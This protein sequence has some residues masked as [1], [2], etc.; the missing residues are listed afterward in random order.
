[1]TNNVT[2]SVLM[3]DA[4]EAEK[5]R[6]SADIKALGFVK[7]GRG[8]D[9]PSGYQAQ[10]YVNTDTREIVL[11]VAGTNDW[12]DISGD[13]AANLNFAT[14]S[15]YHQQFRDGLEYANQINLLATEQRSDYEGYK[16]TTVGHSLGGGI[17]QIYSHTFGWEGYSW[18]A[19]QA[20]HVIQSEGYQAQLTALGLTA[21]GVS[22]KFVNY[23]ENGSIVSELPVGD[24][25][26]L[27]NEQEV[28]HSSNLSVLLGPFIHTYLQ[29]RATQALSY[30][31]TE[32]DT[33][34]IDGYH[35]VGGTYDGWYLEEPN[36]DVGVFDWTGRASDEKAAELNAIRQQRTEHNQHLE[37]FRSQHADDVFGH[38]PS[39]EAYN[40]WLIQD[41]GQEYIWLHGND[42][43][44]IR[45]DKADQQVIETVFDANGNR[46]IETTYDIES[47]EVTHT[48]QRPS[49]SL[50]QGASLLG[51]AAS[52]GITVEELLQF[53]PLLEGVD[54][55][56]AGQSVYLPDSLLSGKLSDLLSVDSDTLAAL[57]GIGL[58]SLSIFGDVLIDNLQ[59]YIRIAE[60][61]DSPLILDLDGDGVETHAKSSNLHFDLDANSFMEQTGWVGA[62]DGL[63][64]VDRNNNGLIDDGTELFGNHT[65]LENGEKAANGFEAL[66]EFDT[67]HDGQVN[68]DDAAFDALRIWRDVNQNGQT[69]SGELSSL[70]DAGVAS[71]R[72]SYD[73][74]NFIDDNNNAHRQVGSFTLNDG[75]TRDL[76]DVWF[77]VDLART[78][79]KDLIDVN[80][81]IAQLPDIQGMGHVRSLHQAMARD[82]S[83]ELQRLVEKFTQ[84]ES[85]ADRHALMPEL[86]YRW[87]GVW[88]VDPTSRGDYVNDA[89]KVEAI[90]AFFGKPFYQW[91]GT[92]ENP[93][94]NA[95]QDIHVA[96][97]QLQSHIY[98]KLAFQTHYKHLLD[99]VTWQYESEGAVSFNTEHLL[100]ALPLGSKEGTDLLYVLDV[101]NSLRGLNDIGEQI[102]LQASKLD[103][104]A[105]KEFWGYERSVVTWQ[106][107]DAFLSTSQPLHQ[108]DHY[109]NEELYGGRSAY[110]NDIL[111]GDTRD[112]QLSGGQGNDFLFGGDGDDQLE[113]GLGNDI[114]IGGGGNDSLFG[115]L[116]SDTYYWSL[117]DG[118]DIVYNQKSTLY[119][120]LDDL[121]VFQFGKDVTAE[122]ITWARSNDDLVGYVTSE[123]GISNQLTF[124]HWFRGA[125]S[126][127][128]ELR[129][130]DG[131]V[132]DKTV[133][134]ASVVIL[135]T[136]GDDRVTSPSSGDDQ[137]FGLDGNDYLNG[138]VG[139]DHL[140]G[141]D[142]DDE[143]QGGEGDDHLYGGSGSDKL[144]GNDGSDTYYWG[145]GSGHDA[146][147]EFDMYEDREAQYWDTV[148][149]GEGITVDDITW[150]RSGDHLVAML[151]DSDFN[152]T[153]TLV[154]WF[155]GS[156]HQVESIR[157]HDGTELDK[158]II[159]AAVIIL[160]SEWNDSLY[161]YASD[162]R[163][164]GLSGDDRIHGYSGNDVLDGGEGNDSLT[165][166]AGND[167]YHWGRGSGNDTVADY[168]N[169]D[170][171]N[172][173]HE[174]VLQFGEG[175]SATDIVWSRQYDHL[176]ANLALEE[177]GY[178][179]LTLYHWFSGAYYQ[180]DQLR[181][182]DGTLLDKAT[183]AA[184]AVILG[185]AGNDILQGINDRDDHL[186]GLAGDDSLYGQSG[187]DVLDGGAGN[188]TLRGDTGNDTYL[189]GRGSGHDV[190]DDYSS[191]DSYNSDHNDRLQ[192]GDGIAEADIVWSRSG[193]DLIAT[194]A[195]NGLPDDRLT[196]L[197][198]FKGA[199]YQVESIQLHDGTLLDKR[200]IEDAL[201]THGTAGDD[202]LVGRDDN[203]DV[204]YGHA[205]N[206]T[207]NGGLGD[208]VLIGGAGNDTYQWGL[209]AGNDQIDDF[210]ETDQANATH[211]DTLQFGEGLTADDIR[212]TQAD[213]DLIATLTNPDGSENHLRLV[214]WF[215]GED[216]Q[217]E[218]IR[219]FDGTTLNMSAF[220]APVVIRGT[221]NGEYLYGENNSH[222]ILQAL[223][224]G[225]VLYGRSGNDQLDGGAGNDSL[226][227][228]A[229]D[230]VLIG[231]ADDDY[232]DGGAGNDTYH[233]G[234]GSG[235]DR[236]NDYNSA[237]NSNPNHIDVL[238]FG[239]GIRA[240]DLVW[241]RSSNHL[242]ATLTDAD[243]NSETLRL[244]SWFSGAQYRVE[245]I[246]LD[247]GT[248]LNPSDIEDSIIIRGTDNNEYL[249]GYSD[250]HD[251]MMGLG[252][253]DVLYGRGGNDRLDG[254]AGNDSLYGEAGDDVLIG[255]ADDDYLDGGAGNDTYHWG[256]G[257]G[258]D[259]IND[260]NNADNSNPNHIDVLQFGEG[261]R[262]DDLVWSRSSNHLIA[263]LTDADGNSETLR[264]QSWFS[265][266]QYRVEQIRLDD[267]TLLNPSDI[268]D[269]I[270]IRGTDNNEYLYGYSDSH[271]K[272]MGL[273][274]GDVL[275]GRSGNDQ[276]DGGAGND[277]LYGE[278]GDDVLIGAAGADYLSGGAGADR[279][280]FEALTDSLLDQADIIADFDRDK[281]VLDLSALDID[282]SNL[283]IAVSG[284]YTDVQIIDQS[285]LVRLQG[286]YYDLTAEHF[287][288]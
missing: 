45:L 192:I 148:Q 172:P 263:T 35:Y 243:G 260:Y 27:G 47:G 184:T 271:D 1:M 210:D 205:G 250:S 29:H 170:A 114:L 199:D 159:E 165:G 131:S 191:S 238:Q 46:L 264:L 218:A 171:N 246:R 122:N 249:Y 282:F 230:D 157:L 280:V 239:E 7:L 256:R 257:S 56:E 97:G 262:A 232:L 66:A 125:L 228:E 129:L 233:W 261:I 147:Y 40:Q 5:D 48:Y 226:Y 211:I 140:Y 28:D 108:G 50:E 51:I 142:G 231:G 88:D 154:G 2:L 248:L 287:V 110:D 161:G 219:L 206:D 6:G 73:L 107:D 8:R 277:S 151:H 204:L 112:N 185:T 167:V 69:D 95:S 178:E 255:G 146:I 119:S 187:D 31:N 18:D 166:G 101:A 194:V 213:S 144:K 70:T 229:G 189:W 100:E 98:G 273:G 197:H 87:S 251:K 123:T 149:L 286:N 224:G 223:G 22:D 237:D 217:V 245:Q 254:G 216:Y 34:V 274:G 16:V 288:L 111:L 193:D 139:S 168:D 53:N 93:E 64:V 55:L 183:V 71:L 195:K 270:I 212:W 121:D 155:K 84:T 180:V 115:G 234:R 39:G 20:S 225:D 85:I 25:E 281:D 89:R 284:S 106:E 80:E 169:T 227:G 252:G 102:R 68:A 19:P 86:L 158:S 3:N 135:G 49:L 65:W 152:D 61:R 283:D 43:Q 79:A 60:A 175:I 220:S 244:Q 285:F 240:D 162:D 105:S 37:T 24:A 235:N 188:D 258:N 120:A 198:W 267:G 81:T 275:Y 174:D 265:G 143:L 276:L 117:G 90:E 92:G 242:I 173:D 127:V 30:F 54:F 153:L 138:G 17:A 116:G 200:A 78:Q 279:F 132:L 104:S 124:K 164:Y 207:L 179:S 177:G 176:V 109:F 182:H 67:N 82:E 221:E 126:Q 128:D 118:N 269:S 76:V 253:G 99:L 156:D 41:N 236:I 160:G 268:E 10:A 190:L 74:T 163:I 96:I 21:K 33:W 32:Q 44:S 202:H 137:M 203:D 13:M 266:A 9:L 241:S 214:N 57:Y 36:P 12:T 247:D 150:S 141:D 62:D 38:S 23:T 215:N 58:G 272:M 103:P 42:G 94:I 201:I 134:E 113:G 181:L 130:N 26:F 15:A 186:L 59:E 145:R 75:S 222:D 14:S 209:N 133:I 91:M 83:G 259:R 136:E 52:L 77:E 63:L 11:A 4:Y 278:A 208:D 72:T 196:F